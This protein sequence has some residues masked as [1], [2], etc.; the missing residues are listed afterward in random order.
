LSR[1]LASDGMLAILDEPTEG[2]DVDGV[3]AVAAAT[4]DLAGRGRTIVV[5]SHDQN[6][7]KGAQ[8]VVDLNVKPV[9]RVSTAPRTVKPEADAPQQEGAAQ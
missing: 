3:A 9:P 4:R 1:A 2:F 7:L 6:F 5:F 8:A